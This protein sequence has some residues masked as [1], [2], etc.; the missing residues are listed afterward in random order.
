MSYSERGRHNPF[1]AYMAGACIWFTPRQLIL[2]G[3]RLEGFTPE[4]PVDAEAYRDM[5]EMVAH[6]AEI[7]RKKYL[8]GQTP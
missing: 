8:G 2:L 4:G 7:K 5:Q 6:E 1:D 3:D